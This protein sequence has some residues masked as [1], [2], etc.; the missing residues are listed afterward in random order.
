VGL[1]V[2]DDVAR[3]APA[4]GELFPMVRVRGGVGR[5]G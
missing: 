1:I 2:G 3:S 5:N 4:P